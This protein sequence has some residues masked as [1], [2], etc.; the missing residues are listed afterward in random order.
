MHTY[1]RIQT[2]AK[3]QV[4]VTPWPHVPMLPLLY[5]GSSLEAGV[6]LHFLQ[7]PSTTERVLEV[8][9]GDEAA[10]AVDS[11]GQDDLC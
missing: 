7:P 2:D 1:T 6:Y 4:S 3:R 5:K 8:S 10:R 11:P 9:H